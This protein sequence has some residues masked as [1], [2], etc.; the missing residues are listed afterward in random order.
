MAV[1]EVIDEPVVEN[2]CPVRAENVSVVIDPALSFNVERGI[3]SR[4]PF[5]TIFANKNEGFVKDEVANVIHDA[6]RAVVGIMSAGSVSLCYRLPLA[7]EDV[8]QFAELLCFPLLLHA[9]GFLN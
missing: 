7:V 4:R 5:R 8:A 3:F 9:S 6:C 2:G 1:P